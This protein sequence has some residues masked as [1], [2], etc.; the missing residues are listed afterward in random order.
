MFL[1]YVFSRDLTKLHSKEKKIAISFLSFRMLCLRFMMSFPNTTCLQNLSSKPFLCLFSFFPNK[2]CNPCCSCLGKRPVMNSTVV[3]GAKWFL[4]HYFF[5]MLSVRI[6]PALFF[7]WTSITNPTG[8]T[9]LCTPAAMKPS[10]KAAGAHLLLIPPETWTFFR[11]FAT[12][13]PLYGFHPILCFLSSLKSIY[14][15]LSLSL[16]FFLTAKLRNYVFIYI[17]FNN[18]YLK[19]V[20][21]AEEKNTKRLNLLQKVYLPLYLDSSQDFQNDP[22]FPGTI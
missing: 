14:L 16:F 12:S 18:F 21:K 2:P 15:S 8:G 20:W 11:F 9:A 1:S 6:H 19:M 13:L 3:W 10:S 17:Y 7:S 5:L 22:G 4:F